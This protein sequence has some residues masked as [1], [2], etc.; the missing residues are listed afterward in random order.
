MQVEKEH[1]KKKLTKKVIILPFPENLAR[2]ILFTLKYPK[3]HFL[4]ILNSILVI[5][6]MLIQDVKFSTYAPIIELMISF[7]PMVPYS[8]KSI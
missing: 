6:L 8:I 3:H 7:V 2:I 1:M 5:T 4:V